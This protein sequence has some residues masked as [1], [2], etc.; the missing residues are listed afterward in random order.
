LENRFSLEIEAGI[1]LHRA[2]DQYTD[3]HPAV[4]GSYKRLDPKFRRYAGIITDI[5]FDHL[6][7]LNWSQYYNEQLKSFSARTL[8]IL[9][10]EKAKL[11][12]AAWQ[13]ASHMQKHNSLAHYG[14]V[15]FL[16]RSLIYLS[17]KLKRPSP[18]I[19][20]YSHCKEQLPGFQKDLK[21]FY[22][23]V[24]KFCDEWKRLN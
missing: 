14:E 13:S 15:E 12:D 7:A 24:I 9:R 5:V 11:T 22:P 19:E 16:E 8:Q 17:G 21:K 23:E 4:K 3:S 18:L 20:S 2:I 1:L 10:V 6:L